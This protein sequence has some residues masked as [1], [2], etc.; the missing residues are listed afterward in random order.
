MDISIGPILYN[1]SKN[2]IKNFYKNISK[3]GVSKIYFGELTC[4]NKGFSIDEIMEIGEMVKKEGKEFIISTPP[5]IKSKEEIEYLKMLLKLPFPLEMNSFAPLSLSIKSDLIAGVYLSIY[6]PYSAGY[7]KSLGFKR[8]VIPFELSK[9]DIKFMDGIDLEIYAYGILPIGISWRCYTLRILRSNRCFR[10]CLNYPDGIPVNS[11]D[12][13]SIFIINGKVILTNKNL[14]LLEYI[15][16]LRD[17]GI[18]TIR[19]SPQM[20]RNEELVDVFIEVVSGKMKIDRALDILNDI[21]D[22]ELFNGWYLGN[23]AYEYHL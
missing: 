11:I 20:D 10:Q 19:I 7:L 14:S 8:I 12:G 21:K 2:K 15:N 22:R 6:N 18:S 17:T 23:I 3:K 1:W 13:N 5:L 16:E 4:I 9:E